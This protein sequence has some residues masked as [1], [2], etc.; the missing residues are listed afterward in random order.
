[1]TASDV[2]DAGRTSAI[3]SASAEPAVT[4]TPGS[5]VDV[6]S[7]PVPEELIERVA[8]RVA[9]LVTASLSQSGADSPWL[10]LDGALAYTGFTRDKLYKLT[11]AKAIPFRKKEDGQ[12]L[13]FHKPE[14]DGWLESHYP[15]Q[16][17]LA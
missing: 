2:Y 11:A 14:L 16:D 1:M 8:A 10:D 4:P 5:Q 12:G 17:R 6:L 7:L 13:L 9:E 15:R 3:A